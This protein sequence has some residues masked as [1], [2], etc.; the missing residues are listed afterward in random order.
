MIARFDDDLYEKSEITHI[1]H[2]V[3]L[4]VRDEKGLFWF[5][6][7]A[8]EDAFGM[9]NHYET[10]GGGI[11]EN[12]SYEDAIRR[13][14]LEEIGYE[15]LR[16]QEVGMIID[17]YYLIHRETHSYFF[18]VDI[19]ST[20]PHETHLTESEKTLFSGVIQIPKEE[21]CERL[22]PTSTSHRVDILVQRRDL[23]AFEY[24]LEKGLV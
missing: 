19:D 10:I 11:E 14:I 22:R 18:V 8:G 2:T 7:I 23:C 12:E 6:K 16:I 17:R 13:E 1:R 9:R 21:V 20:K 5:L 24:A 15:A 3:R 4:I